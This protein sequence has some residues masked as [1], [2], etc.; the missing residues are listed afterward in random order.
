M[1]TQEKGRPA[2]RY[3]HHIRKG[4]IFSFTLLEK[5]EGN[6]EKFEEGTERFRRDSKQGKKDGGRETDS[7]TT[8]TVK[9]LGK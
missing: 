4:R 1:K 3:S 7:V 6:P 2:N 5:K 8:E 9:R